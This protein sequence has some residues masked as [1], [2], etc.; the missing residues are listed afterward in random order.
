LHDEGI[1]RIALKLAPAHP[2]H[3]TIGEN[4]TE[5]VAANHA[6]VKLG[7]GGAHSKYRHPSLPLYQQSVHRVDCTLGK[8]MV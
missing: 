1:P 7:M 8:S 2:I 5:R 6:A 4:A 3:Q